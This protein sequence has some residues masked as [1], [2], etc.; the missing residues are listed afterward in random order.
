MD[1][2]TFLGIVTAGVLFFILW[3]P[4]DLAADL[5]RISAARHDDRSMVRG[6]FRA[7]VVGDPATGPLRPAVSGFPFVATVG[8][9]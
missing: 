4:L 3:A 9:R 1:E 5:S 6:F 7:L 8:Q 2:S